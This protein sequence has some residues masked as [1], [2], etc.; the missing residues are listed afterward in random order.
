[1]PDIRHK[2]C[3]F[4]TSE[5]K[6]LLIEFFSGHLGMIYQFYISKY[7][8][9]ISSNIGMEADVDIRTLPISE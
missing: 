2:E 9:L 8:I 6:L 3:G 7:P 5:R 1:M 4:E